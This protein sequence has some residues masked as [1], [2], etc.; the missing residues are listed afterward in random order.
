MRARGVCLPV[1]PQQVQR[2]NGEAALSAREEKIVAA[3]KI[4]IG[5][6]WLTA[7]CISVQEGS[8][9]SESGGCY[10]LIPRR[11]ILRRPHMALARTRSLSLLLS[12]T[13]SL[14]FINARRR[15]PLKS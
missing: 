2:L 15:A 12:R 13:H 14:K 8:G 3:L 5:G 4:S 10:T 6:A 9:E 7:R 11:S 1:F